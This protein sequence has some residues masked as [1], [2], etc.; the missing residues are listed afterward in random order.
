MVRQ[1]LEQK[2]MFKESLRTVLVLCDSTDEGANY[3]HQ[4]GAPRNCNWKHFSAGAHGVWV[5]GKWEN[6]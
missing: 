2:D 3:L 4:L 6:D 5:E 1:V